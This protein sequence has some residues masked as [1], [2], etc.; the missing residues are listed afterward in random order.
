MLQA[1]ISSAR[2]VAGSDGPSSPFSASSNIITTVAGTGTQGFSGDGG[3]GAS[4]ALDWPP[5]VDVDD[6]GNVYIADYNNQRVRRVA[7]GT[8]T[9]TTILGTANEGFTGD[10]GLA[11]DARLSYPV[12]VAVRGHAELF[13]MSSGKVRRVDLATGVVTTVAGRIDPRGMGPLA[14]AQLADPPA[15]TA[16][17]VFTLFAGGESGTLQAARSDVVAV[18]A[19]RYPHAIATVSR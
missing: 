9:I 14:Q 17:P 5:D 18:V 6:L 1:R 3:P 2:I 8:G 19:G 13:V 12:G 15:F 11:V 4:A 10:G 7:A 16:T